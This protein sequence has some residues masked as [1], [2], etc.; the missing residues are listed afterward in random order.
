MSQKSVTF[1][2][3]PRLNSFLRKPQTSSPKNE[4]PCS[5][6]G[7]KFTLQT[8]FCLEPA[9]S[10]LNNEP[11]CSLLSCKFARQTCYCI[12]PPPSLAVLCRFLT[13]LQSAPRV[14]SGNRGYTYP[15]PNM[16]Q[17]RGCRHGSS[18]VRG[19]RFP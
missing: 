9:A 12:E 13:P 16:L 7:C 11:P 3:S 18:L 4:P 6:L 15:P 10:S 2:T 8:C 19:R 1:S 17:S 5:F 14:P